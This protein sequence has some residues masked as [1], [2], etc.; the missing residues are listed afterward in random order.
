MQE[1]KIIPDCVYQDLLDECERVGHD[2]PLFI[3]DTN[4]KMIAVSLVYNVIVDK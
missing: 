1:Y 3:K 2:G 4:I